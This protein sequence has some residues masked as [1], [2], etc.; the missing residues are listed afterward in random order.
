MRRNGH[1]HESKEF[2]QKNE[3][4]FFFSIS[5]PSFFMRVIFL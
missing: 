3:F 4:Q 2:K 1:L 5:N